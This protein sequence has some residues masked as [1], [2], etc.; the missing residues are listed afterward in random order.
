MSHS[1]PQ[2]IP[3]ATQAEVVFLT[4]SQTIYLLNSTSNGLGFLNIRLST[5]LYDA[6][7]AV[8]PSER[9]FGSLLEATDPLLLRVVA[10]IDAGFRLYGMDISTVLDQ[11]ID[12]FRLSLASA[13]KT[14]KWVAK[15]S[16]KGRESGTFPI[17]LVGDSALQH[18]F[19]VSGSS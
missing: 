1:D 14:V 3:T 11:R 18:N 19:C 10:L 13:P 5:D 6:L 15:D 17:V 9:T 4:L 7:A 8:P 16:Q 12:V 2:A